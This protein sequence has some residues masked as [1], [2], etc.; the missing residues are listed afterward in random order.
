MSTCLESIMAKKT[1]ALLLVAL[2]STACASEAARPGPARPP[3]VPPTLPVL[4]SEGD[5]APLEAPDACSW[6]LSTDAVVLGELTAV[7]VLDSPV[8][9]TRLE[10]TPA[11]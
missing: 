11:G 5:C 8:V 4:V 7:R 9:V 1:F 3:L 2:A 10:G 6:A